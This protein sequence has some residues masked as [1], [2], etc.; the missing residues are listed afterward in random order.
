M[1]ENLEINLKQ[2]LTCTMNSEACTKDSMNHGT[3]I[4]I[5]KFKR[6]SGY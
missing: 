1:V 5:G 2:M 6:T 3:T 4:L